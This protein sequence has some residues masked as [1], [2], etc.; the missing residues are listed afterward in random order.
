[1]LMFIS[2]MAKYMQKFDH[3]YVLE[4]I[5]LTVLNDAGHLSFLTYFRSLS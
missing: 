4:W 2:G 5:V 1:M 3:Q